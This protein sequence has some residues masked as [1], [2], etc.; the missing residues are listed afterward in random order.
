M[1]EKPLL[2]IFNKDDLIKQPY[3]RRRLQRRFPG[4][5]FVS[6]R[7]GNGIDTLL[8]L[9]VRETNRN[10]CQADLLVP[11]AR[12]DIIA[13]LH[14]SGHVYSEEYGDD[15]ISIK[16]SIPPSIRD[17]VKIFEDRSEEKVDDTRMGDK[18][19]QKAGRLR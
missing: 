1:E 3:M 13:Q 18:L 5:A 16:A 6:A 7:Q 19:H 17:A 10:L 2:T 15:G 12:Y 11:F 4:A 14:R 8:H 9:L